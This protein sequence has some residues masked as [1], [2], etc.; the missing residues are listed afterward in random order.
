MTTARA[1]RERLTRERILDCAVAHADRYGLASV[2]IRSLAA[3]LGVHPM[4]LYHYFEG[5]EAILEAMTDVLLAEAPISEVETWQEWVTEVFAS[6]RSLAQAHPGAF[7][8][9]QTSPASGR[10]AEL[11]SERGLRCFL[12]A[13]FTPLDA[14]AALRSVSLAA[15]G[16]SANERVRSLRTRDEITDRM[17]HVRASLGLEVSAQDLAEI[18]LWGFT[19]STL[20]AG[21]ESR[22]TVRP[23]RRSSRR[24]Q[25]K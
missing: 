16:L 6:M 18:D 20:L 11:L 12:V 2:T 10:T 24:T 14:V 8:V 4:S 5:K 9:V 3:E 13:G 7:E 17:E 23:T 25:E 21:L 1:K 15:L 22:T 19:L